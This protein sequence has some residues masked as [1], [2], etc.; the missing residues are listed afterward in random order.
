MSERSGLSP[1][2][3]G[4]RNKMSHWPCG[5]A[6]QPRAKLH[7]ASQQV[8]VASRVGQKNCAS[9]IAWNVLN[10][11]C[12]PQGDAEGA[13][14]MLCLQLPVP[15]GIQKTMES[16]NRSPPAGRCFFRPIE[17]EELVQR[18]VRVWRGDPG[19][20]LEEPSDHWAPRVVHDAVAAGAAPEVTRARPLKAPLGAPAAAQ[21]AQVRGHDTWRALGGHP[22]QALPGPLKTMSWERGRWPFV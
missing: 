22:A 5:V 15:A 10:L 12:L 1:N 6:R 18:P 20:A 2:G 16:V 11:R 19:L 14:E 17:A 13:R 21:Q 8:A 3:D 7:P 9:L 4:R